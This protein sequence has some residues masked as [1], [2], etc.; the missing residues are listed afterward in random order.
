M[1]EA[2]VDEVALKWQLTRVHFS[3]CG[4]CLRILFSFW[5]MSSVN[6]FG[7]CLWTMSSVTFLPVDNVK[8]IGPVLSSLKLT[9]NLSLCQNFP[10]KS[11]FCTIC[12]I[13]ERFLVELYNYYKRPP[14]AETSSWVVLQTLFSAVSVQF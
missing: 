8:W 6:V 4:Q 9:F 2:V 1:T 11:D 5:T 14:C 13:K 12:T 7:R 3:P 10:I